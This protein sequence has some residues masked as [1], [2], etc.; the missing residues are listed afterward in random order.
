MR[1]S[2]SVANIVTVSGDSVTNLDTVAGG[3]VTSSVTEPDES[4]TKAAT[5]TGGVDSR[6]AGWKDIGYHDNSQD[7]REQLHPV[8]SSA[9]LAFLQKQ[10]TIVTSIPVTGRPCMYS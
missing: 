4:V 3:S 10:V 2:T 5:L 7:E 1:G 9:S 8:E 6:G